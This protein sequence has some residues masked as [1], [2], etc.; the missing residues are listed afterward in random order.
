MQTKTPKW[1][2]R[3]FL[4]RFLRGGLSLR[5]TAFYFLQS[6]HLLIA[7]AIM[8]KNSS[9]KYD[10]DEEKEDAQ[11]M[12]PP[13]SEDESADQAEEEFMADTHDDLPDGFFDEHI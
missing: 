1:R 3:G 8:R 10:F 9:A 13:L 12:D 5:L 6:N 7:L 2:L 11:V 4:F